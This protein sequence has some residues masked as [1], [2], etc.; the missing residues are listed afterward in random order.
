MAQMYDVAI[1]GGGISGLYTAWRL[2]QTTDLRVVLMESSGRFGGRYQTVVLP[3][4]FPAD[5]G[6]MR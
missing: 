5:L 1:I 2:S 6:A 4:G 3:G